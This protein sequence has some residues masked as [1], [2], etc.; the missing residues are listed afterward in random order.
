M[1]K[2]IKQAAEKAGGLKAKSVLLVVPTSYDATTQKKLK[3]IL[4]QEFAVKNVATAYDAQCAL[5]AVGKKTGLVVLA[6][7][8]GTYVVPIVNNNIQQHAITSNS[9]GNKALGDYLISQNDALDERTSKDAI[10]DIK[11]KLAYVALDYDEELQKPMSSNN[12]VLKNGQT[13]TI[14]AERFRCPEVLFKPSIIGLE[15]DGVH[16]ATYNSIMK[17]DVDIRKDLYA[18]LV[19]VGTNAFA[20]LDNRIQKEVKAL[21]RGMNLAFLAPESMAAEARMKGVQTIFIGAEALAR[22]TAF[23]ETS[24]EHNTTEPVKTLERR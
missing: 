6:S 1:L 17:Y 12:Y 24:I 9:V 20:G 11:E 14:G 5:E 22:T 2:G 23:K 7:G 3:G 15:Q 8:G 21:D 10:R 4:T 19:V 13:A 16:V 18:S